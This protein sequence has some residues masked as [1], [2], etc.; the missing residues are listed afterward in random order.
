MIT[1][2]VCHSP[3]FA[4]GGSAA[5]EGLEGESPQEATKKSRS[6]IGKGLA[7][8]ISHSSLSSPHPTHICITISA[9]LTLRAEESLMENI[10]STSHISPLII[11]YKLCAPL[12]IT[13]PSVTQ[14]KQQKKKEKDHVPQGQEKRKDDGG[15]RLFREDEEGDT[16]VKSG[17]EDKIVFQSAERHH[18]DYGLINMFTLFSRKTSEQCRRTLTLCGSAEDYK[19]R[20]E[21]ERDPLSVLSMGLGDRWSRGSVFTHHNRKDDVIYRVAQSPALLLIPERSLYPR[22]FRFS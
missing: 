6:I 19:A 11:K 1:T 5:F 4:S 20:T 13:A 3:W 12:A 2:L 7:K 16:A 17:P 8:V 9:L 18:E 10:P 15:A 22:A 14:R 21:L